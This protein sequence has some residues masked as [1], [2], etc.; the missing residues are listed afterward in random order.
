MMSSKVIDDPWFVVQIVG[1]SIFSVL[2]YL[3]QKLNL[4]LL[5]FFSL[6]IFASLIRY[7]SD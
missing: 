7:R 5:Q 4:I 6:K 1:H 2:F 3:T